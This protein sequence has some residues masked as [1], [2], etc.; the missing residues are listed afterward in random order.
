MRVYALAYRDTMGLPMQ[1]FW[2]LSG[3]VPRLLAGEAKGAL[4]ANV[5]ATHDPKGAAEMIQG[6]D[7]RSPEPVKLSIHARIAATSVR[8]E[9][10]FGRLKSMK[11]R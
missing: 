7:E 9:E 4:E 11:M 6:L 8:D 2:Q 1:V 5:L 3:T 10:G